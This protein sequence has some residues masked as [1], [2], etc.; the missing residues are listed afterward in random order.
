MKIAGATLNQTPLDWSNNLTNIKNAIV[1]AKKD[2]VSILCLPELCITGYGCEDMFLYPWVA[3]R[4][5]DELKK[6]LPLTSGITVTLGLPMWYQ[7]KIYNTICLVKD[8]QILGFQAKQTLPNYGVHYEQ[9]WFTPWNQGQQKLEINGISYQFG[10]YIYN[11]DEAVIGF[12]I[13]EEAWIEDRPACRLVEQKVNLI[14]NPSA[15]HFAL[16]KE[17]SRENLVISSSK[18]FNCTYVYAN[19]LGNEAGRIIYDGD[20][21][22]GQ[23]GQLLAL[24]NRFSKKSFCLTSTEVYL[25]GHQNSSGDERRSLSLFQQFTKAVTLGLFDYLRK[26]YSKGFVLSLSGGADSSSLLVLVAEMVKSGVDE[27]G[28]EGFLKQ[29]NREDLLTQVSSS[30]EIISKLLIAAYQGSKNSSEATLQSAK[31]LAESV[32]ATFYHW[33][34]DQ[35]VEVAVQVVEKELGR[36]LSWDTDDIALQNIQAR[37]RSPIIWMLANITSSILLTTSNRSEGSVGYTTMDGDSS[38]SLAPIAGINK[39]FLVEWLRWAEKELGYTGLSYVNKLIPTAELRPKENLQTDEQD[40]MP[41]PVLQQIEMLFIRERL[42]PKAIFDKLN[43]EIDK[44]RIAGYIVKFFKLWTR[45]QWKRERIAPSF[46]LDDYNVDPRSWFRFPI[47]SGGFYDELK[48]LEQIAK[49]NQ[50]IT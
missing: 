25:N 29:V 37:S 24:G 17:K 18:D 40:L 33:T 48:E 49:G 8:G 22:I 20:V 46:H 1:Q 50:S 16:N 47:L 28:V 5:L 38:G 13:C 12:E 4:A 32:G 2:N 41:Y 21:I 34:I 26:S 11:I 43:T 30:E 14:L 6:A 42:S 45:N 36:K 19:Q 7:T 15:S 27:L 10:D 3:E 44:Q 39:S 31:S 9:R 23:K 35:P